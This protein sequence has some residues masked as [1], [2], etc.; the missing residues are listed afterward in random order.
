MSAY[1]HEMSIDVALSVDLR[2]SKSPA[3]DGD[4]F[5]WTIFP[6]LDRSSIIGAVELLVLRD[7]N[8]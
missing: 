1:Q 8:P 3:P 5:A 2:K 7:G 4:P 6:R